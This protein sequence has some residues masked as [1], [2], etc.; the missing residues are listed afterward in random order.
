MTRNAAKVFFTRDLTNEFS[1][2][3]T[4]CNYFQFKGQGQKEQPVADAA[5]FWQ[6][7][8]KT[9]TMRGKM[10]DDLAYETLANLIHD[11]AKIVEQVEKIHGERGVRA[12]KEKSD[13][14]HSTP[15][16]PIQS[17]YKWFNIEERSFKVPDQSFND[18]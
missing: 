15:F 17:S 10:V 12:M 9:K 8:G 7:L 3:V 14:T 16:I 11:P 4:K 6:I 13:G 2:V 1:E 5:T 18:Y